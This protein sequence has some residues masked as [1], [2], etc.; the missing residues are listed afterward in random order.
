MIGLLQA[1]LIKCNIKAHDKRKRLRCSG[2]ILIWT[3]LSFEVMTILSSGDIR[4]ERSL[5]LEQ[6]LSQLQ[7]V[8]ISQ[9]IEVSF[10]YLILRVERIAAK[11]TNSQVKR[12]RF[13]PCFPHGESLLNKI[14]VNHLCKACEDLISISYLQEDETRADKDHNL[15][16]LINNSQGQFT[17][18]THCF[19]WRILQQGKSQV[20]GKLFKRKTIVSL[21]KS[22]QRITL[23]LI[24]KVKEIVKK[25]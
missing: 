22:K 6:R 23:L 17:E 24:R 12:Y 5:H 20:S 14:Y 2:I 7:S 8:Y 15:I 4:E 9:G 3:C 10:L 11:K 13:M 21:N 19:P 16:N 25:T 18:D 1:Y